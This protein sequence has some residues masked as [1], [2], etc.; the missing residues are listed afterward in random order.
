MIFG[1]K[2][3][4]IILTHTV[5]V[6]YCYK[7]TCV[8]YDCFV[9]QGS[10]QSPLQSTHSTVT[11]N[12]F[13]MFTNL[14]LHA[15][16]HSLWPTGSSCGSWRASLI[17]RTPAGRSP[18]ALYAHQSPHTR[19]LWPSHSLNGLPYP[20]D[21]WPTEKN[22]IWKREAGRDTLLHEAQMHVRLTLMEQLI[23]PPLLWIFSTRSNSWF[24]A[25]SSWR[26][27]PS[28]R[29]MGSDTPPVKS[30]RASAVFPPSKAS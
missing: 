26:N 13:Q 21:S 11:L 4:W 17:W 24:L 22:P 8:T 1:I 16:F 29:S 15:P 12:S 27:F 18:D 10:T 20:P 19:D 23:R 6:V 2:E 28:S 9:L 14:S 30:T 25:S 5:Y 3:K 7:Y